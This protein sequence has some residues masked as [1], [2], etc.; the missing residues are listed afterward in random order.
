MARALG[1]LGVGVLSVPVAGEAVRLCRVAWKR[2][3]TPWHPHEL[4]F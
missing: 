2:S 3:Q 4:F 1:V